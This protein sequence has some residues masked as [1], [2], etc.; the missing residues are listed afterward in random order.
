MTIPREERFL[1]YVS[2][3]ADKWGG[4][5]SAADTFGKHYDVHPYTSYIRHGVY[6]EN[7]YLYLD[8]AWLEKASR[9]DAMLLLL[10]YRSEMSITLPPVYPKAL[11]HAIRRYREGES[12]AK[13]AD[14]N[15][16]R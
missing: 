12:A 5:T 15:A 10:S 14:G 11:L 2:T 6:Y 13:T 4:F 1:L 7:V 9:D 8:R 16:T 3:K